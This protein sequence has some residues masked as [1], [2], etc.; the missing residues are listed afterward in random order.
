[1]NTSLPLLNPIRPDVLAMQHYVVQPATG[2]IK[3][4]AME[5]PYSL[6]SLLQTELAQI[7]G[8]V[9]LNRY[10]VSHS[11]VIAAIRKAQAIPAQYGIMLG[12]GSDEI[13]HL[14]IQACATDN[15]VVMAPTPGFVM[16]AMSAQLN[17]CRFIG[18]PLRADFELD[19]PLMLASIK[20]HTPAILFLANPN[21]P[22]GNEWSTEFIQACINAMC[23]HGGLVVIDEAYQPF[24]NHSWLS[25]L[26]DSPNVVLVRTVSKLGLAGLRLGFLVASPAWI[27]QFD[28]VRPPYNINVLTLAATQFILSHNAVLETQ[29]KQIMAERTVLFDA[30]VNMA[31]NMS[32]GINIQPYPSA[33]NFILVKVPDANQWFATLKSQGI[34][35]KNVSNLSPLLHNCLRLTVGNSAENKALI[36]ALRLLADTTVDK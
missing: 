15:A 25:R 32:D 19:L 7:L 13:L 10:P 34:L 31:E 14:L 17:R 12:N 9:A 20:E 5:N 35:V 29:A 16:Y 36:A 4:D 11:D 28:K 24:S 18:V 2:L 8:Q 6:P 30:L 1:M 26:S 33:A 22:T 27:E 23:L 3:L 21:N